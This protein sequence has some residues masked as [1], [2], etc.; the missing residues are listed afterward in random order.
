MMLWVVMLMTLL[1]WCGR[2]RI[3]ISDQQAERTLRVWYI[4][5]APW[6]VVDPNTREISGIF[7]DILE[8]IAQENNFTIEY[9]YEATRATLVEVLDTNKVDIMAGWIWVTQPRKEHADFSDPVYGSP[10]GVYVRADDERFHGVIGDPDFSVLNDPMLMIATIDG[11]A[12]QQIAHDQFPDAQQLAYPHSIDI[13]QILLA[14][15][16]Q[17]ADVTFAEPSYAYGY[18][19]ANP[20]SLVNIAAD[21]PIRQRA[22]AFM[23]KQWNDE[24][25]ELLNQWIAQLRADG[26]LDQII[27]AHIADPSLVVHYDHSVDE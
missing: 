6:L 21:K 5:Y 11:E 23:V 3:D 12:G 15:D 27:D 26:R 16:T 13:G 22:N 10:I 17:L 4:H 19:Q 7:P 20:D 14:V 2:E 1:V 25:R 24:L 8:Y 18:I 9:V